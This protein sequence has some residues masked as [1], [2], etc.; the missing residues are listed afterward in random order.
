MVD[1]RA[2]LRD[3]IGEITVGDW[4]SRVCRFGPGHGDFPLDQGLSS[5]GQKARFRFSG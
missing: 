3:G 4:E 5:K 1:L 2:D